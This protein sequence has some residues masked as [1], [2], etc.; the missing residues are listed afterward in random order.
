VKDRST[1]ENEHGGVSIGPLFWGG[2]RRKEEF[3]LDADAI[4]FIFFKAESLER[5]REVWVM[6]C[7]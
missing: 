1:R 6:E 7:C 3:T 2:V 5:K 4:F